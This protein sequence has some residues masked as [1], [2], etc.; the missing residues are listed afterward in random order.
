MEKSKRTTEQKW[1]VSVYFSSKGSAES[2]RDLLLGADYSVKLDFV[3]ERYLEKMQDF[4]G[5][6][7]GRKR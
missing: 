6:K 1:R 7:N 2:F 3:P 4:V 5:G